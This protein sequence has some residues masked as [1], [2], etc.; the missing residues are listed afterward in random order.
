MGR[1]SRGARLGSR[2]RRAADARTPHPPRAGGAVRLDDKAGSRR[3]GPAAPGRRRPERP[4]PA[5]RSLGGR[6]AGEP[7]TGPPRRGA[8]RPHAGPPP[9]STRCAPPA[10]APPRPWRWWRS[11]PRCWRSVSPSRC[12]RPAST[13]PPGVVAWLDYSDSGTGDTGRATLKLNVV[14]TGTDSVTVTAAD[15]EG[16]LEDDRPSGVGAR[17]ARRADRGAV[18]LR[19]RHRGREGPRLRQRPG[20]ARE[21]RATATCG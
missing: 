2:G 10:V 9:A 15:L 14:N 12:G 6:P 17:P 13:P 5:P 3:R 4:A 1:E 11:P 18:G 7:P 20:G 21:V 16:G 8:R 19:V